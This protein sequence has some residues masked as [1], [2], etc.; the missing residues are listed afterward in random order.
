MVTV[1]RL[2]WWVVYVHCAILTLL[3]AMFGTFGIAAWATIEGP[4]W[5]LAL[6]P[7]GITVTVLLGGLTWRVLGVLSRVR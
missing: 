1:K 5:L 4:L 6:I 7:L 2:F 3:A